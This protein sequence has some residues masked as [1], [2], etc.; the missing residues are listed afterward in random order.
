MPQ[1][2]RAAI[3]SKASAVTTILCVGEIARSDN[4]QKLAGGKPVVGQSVPLPS[5]KRLGVTIDV[6]EYCQPYEVS[7][8]SVISRKSFGHEFYRRSVTLYLCL[9]SP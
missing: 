3:T 2:L 4:H 5:S 9:S 7:F 8:G 1:G 6:S